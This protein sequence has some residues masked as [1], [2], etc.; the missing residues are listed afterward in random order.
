MSPCREHSELK[1]VLSKLCHR[2]IFDDDEVQQYYV[3]LASLIG[4]WLSERIRLETSPVKNHVR[5]KGP[6]Y[7]VQ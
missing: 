7:R 4:A 1:R 2:S 3:T 6:L 5:A